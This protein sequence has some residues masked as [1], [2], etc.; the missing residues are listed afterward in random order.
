MTIAPVE[1]DDLPELARLYEELV[2][3]EIDLRKMREIYGKIAANPNQVVF[4]A[5]DDHNRLVGSV[6]GVACDDIIG[7]CRPFL[8][9]ENMIVSQNCRGQGVGRK[10]M[11]HIEAWGRERNCYFSMLTSMAHRKDAHKFY[12]SMGY[13]PANV[14]GFKKYL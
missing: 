7:A 4:A 3:V 10:L 11:E 13:D 14:Q 5:R 2:A 12:A 6:M 9:V 8:V 1:A